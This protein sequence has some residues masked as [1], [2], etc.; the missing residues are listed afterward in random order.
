MTAVRQ[1]VLE[2]A[3]LTVARGEHF[4]LRVP[5]LEA[6]SG[7]T[8]AILGP[9]GAGK[10][11]LL[12]V[13]ALLRLPD[14][15]KVSFLGAPVRGHRQ[16]L[17]F[18]RRISL[19]MQDPF[20]LSG[21]VIDNVALPL[22]LRGGNRKEARQHARFWL[23]RFGIPHLSE[24][25]AHSLSGG[26]ARRA[27]LARALV[28]DPALLL[29]DEPFSALD[30]PSRDGLLRDFQHALTPHT[31]VILVT[32]DRSV[33]LSLAQQ[34]AVLAA[35]RVQQVGST[36]EVFRQP[37]CETVAELVGLE[38]ILSGPVT[39]C[40]YGLCRVEVSP[41]VGVEASG[42]SVPGDYVTLCVH[43]E[44]VT[45]ERQSDPSR[46][47]ARN[48]FDARIRSITPHGPGRRVEMEC[49]FPLVALVTRRSAELLA[50]KP[51]EVVSA[52]FKASAVHVFPSRRAH[53]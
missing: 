13:L 7:E 20:L 35:G 32:H 23:E 44:E 19:A 37:A 53:D 49:P 30:P 24:R 8:L 11:T 45:I 5:H 51:G 16:R 26:E 10:S 48:V 31:A 25:Q 46:T 34:V 22:K 2:I 27:S 52:S 40:E 50:L 33:A 9:N 14:Q 17:Q 42:E 18:R 39:A 36:E 3:D 29:L 28:S 12:E 15:G 43:P 41:G 38:T 4:Q 21:C 1:T 6:R 47:T